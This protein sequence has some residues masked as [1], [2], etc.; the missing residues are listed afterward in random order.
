M[1]NLT[2]EALATF[3]EII[4]SIKSG[5][6]SIKRVICKIIATLRKTS[7]KPSSETDSPTNAN[8][9][10]QPGDLKTNGAQTCAKAYAHGYSPLHA[11]GSDRV[12]HRAV[13]TFLLYTKHWGRKRFLHIV[14]GDSAR[15]RSLRCNLR[16]VVWRFVRTGNAEGKTNRLS[17]KLSLHVRPGG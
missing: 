3:Q 15:R 1:S 8:I 13:T 16:E 5:A 17:K 11:L 4:A 9:I 7:T 2:T 10:R 14:I 6:F 12:P